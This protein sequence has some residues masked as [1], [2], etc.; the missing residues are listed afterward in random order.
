VW[1]RRRPA[2]IKR[3]RQ[4]ARTYASRDEA[5]NGID[6]SIREFYRQAYPAVARD[7]VEAIATAINALQGAY[8]RNYDPHMQVSWK[9]FPNN[10]GHRFSP[11]CFRCHDGKHRSD[12]G[13]V[14]S[15]DCSLCHL[16]IE[17]APGPALRLESRPFSALCE[18]LIHGHR[19]CLEA[20]DVPRVSRTHAITALPCVIAMEIARQR[21]QSVAYG[22]FRHT[23]LAKTKDILNCYCIYGDVQICGSLLKKL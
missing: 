3:R 16:L 9:N 6:R 18:T 8:D 15:R 2:E 4:G 22:L 14:L 10:Q 11:G 12:D 20:D 5:R 1:D 19:R 17:R 23:N 7:R 13:T 21:W